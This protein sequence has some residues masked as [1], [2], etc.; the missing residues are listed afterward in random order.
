MEAVWH[1][2][3]STIYS[4]SYAAALLAIVGYNDDRCISNTSMSRLSRAG[5]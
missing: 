2:L 1:V 4:A 5:W 3:V